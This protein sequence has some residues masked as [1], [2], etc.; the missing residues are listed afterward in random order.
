MKSTIHEVNTTSN[1][2]TAKTAFVFI[3]L[4]L[5]AF[6]CKKEDSS[7]LTKDLAKS[8]WQKTQILISADSILDTIPTIVVVSPTCKSDNIWSFDANN[9]TFTLDEGASKCDV[10]DPQIKDQGIIEE[11][12]NG[13]AL[14]VA[15]DGTNEIW[16]I[17]SRSASSFRVS[18][19]ARN[20]SNKLV[21]FRVTFN[22]I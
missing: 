14:R 20:A 16:E 18:Y 11:Q 21:K 8:R 9:N 15:S 1:V 4:T 17:E 13:S 19:F 5:M 6:A 3:L 12:N 7:S 2:K 10:S 22:K